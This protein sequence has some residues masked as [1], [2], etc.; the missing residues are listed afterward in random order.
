MIFSQ[1]RSQGYS[2]QEVWAR[3]K[4]LYTGNFRPKSSIS[5]MIELELTNSLSVPTPPEPHFIYT[6]FFPRPEPHFIYTN[7]FSPA[8]TSFYLHKLSK[9]NFFFVRRSAPRIVFVRH[10]P[11]KLHLTPVH[12]T[13]LTQVM[14]TLISYTYNVL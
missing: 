7:F 11:I 9:I 6:N 13:H 8:R 10:L 2:K 14:Y 4:G 1:R 3:C 5:A 12:L